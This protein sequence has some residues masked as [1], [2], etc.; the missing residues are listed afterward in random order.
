MKSQ[1]I[2]YK[3]S[4]E[5]IT[6]VISGA[7][8]ATLIDAGPAVGAIQSGQIRALAITSATR[9]PELPDVPTMAE[10]GFPELAAS[11]W[12]GLFGPAGIPAPIARR[13][14]AELIRAVRQSEVAERMRSL[15]VVPE[16][17]PGEEL[18]RHLAA[19]IARN[20]EV[21]RTANINTN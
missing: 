8:L 17:R 20:A 10:A 9:S 12:N 21:V 11:F 14:E 15:A 2:P 4:A 13:L 19:E 16:G 5:C 3:S 7:T 6:A 1:K 18:R